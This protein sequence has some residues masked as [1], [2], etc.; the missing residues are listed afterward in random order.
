MKKEI[1]LFILLALFTLNS[2]VK[3]NDTPTRK[4]AINELMPVNNT[5]ATDQNG[6]YDDWIELFNLS[7][8]GLDISGY[9]LSDSKKN[10]IK[11]QIPQGTSISGKSYLV[12]WADKDTTQVGLHAN[13]KLSSLGETVILSKP[14]GTLI[15]EVKYPGQTHELSYSRNPDGTGTFRWQKPTFNWTNNN[16]N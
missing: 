2:C 6:E 13:F 7:D 3:P 15:D 1:P 10:I 9:Y 8:S 11:W 4:I 14:D 12:V 5:T 16:S